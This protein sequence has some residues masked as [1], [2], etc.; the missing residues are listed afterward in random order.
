MFG[1]HWL[2]PIVFIAAVGLSAI[3]TWI[4]REIAIESGC[5][6]LPSSARHIHKTAIPRLGGIA[7]FSTF[8]VV[9]SVTY[10]L[11]R[12]TGAA[13]AGSR[14]LLALIVPGTILFGVGLADD[15]LDV[16]PLVKISF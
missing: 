4:V 5:A 13:S 3:L 14:E 7:I 8:A 2:F 6:A 15:F 10:A 11:M 16:S 12:L 9:T 1:W